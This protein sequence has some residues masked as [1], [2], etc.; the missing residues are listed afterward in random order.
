[1]QRSHCRYGSLAAL[2]LATGCATEPTDT[3]ESAISQERPNGIAEVAS[4]LYSDADATLTGYAV[5]SVG[6]CT[7]QMIGPNMMMTAAH[8]DDVDR[9]ATFFVYRNQDPAQLVTETFFCRILLNT[10]AGSDLTLYA[11][12]PNAAGENP[13]DKYGYLDFDPTQPT[14]N[15]KVYSYWYNPVAS[16][17]LNQALIYSA[18]KVT[19]TSAG[20]W[21]LNNSGAPMSSPIGIG[22]DLWSQPGCSGSAIIDAANHRIMAGPTSTGANDAAGR[23]ALSAK[24]GFE[25]SSV[26]GFSEATAG[27]TVQRTGVDSDN[28][29]R[30]NRFIGSSITPSRYAGRLDKDNDYVF[31]IQERIERILG[32]NQRDWYFLGFN[33]ERR[34]A[35][36]DKPWYT[37]FNPTS[38][39]AHINTPS[40]SL[41]GWETLVHRHLPLE[42]NTKYRVSLMINVAD[43]SVPNNLRVAL[44]RANRVIGPSIVP[45]T[46]VPIEESSF[47][48]PTNAGSGWQLV[49]FALQTQSAS[50]ELAFIV[51]GKLDALLSSV[52]II[53]DDAVMDFDSA[54]K[55]YSWR[56]DNTGGR[57]RIVPDGDDALLPDWA[58]WVTPTAGLA[59]GTDWPLRNRQLAIVPGTP[60]QLCVDV[61][62]AATPAHG[63]TTARSMRLLSAGVEVARTNFIPTQ[64]WTQTCTQPFQVASSDNNLQL[65]FAGPSAS[66]GYYADNIRLVPSCVPNP[67]V[68][69]G[70]TCG[71]VDD[72]CGNQV[73]C[74]GCSDGGYCISNQ[75]IQTCLPNRLACQNLA[76]G[77]VDDGCGHQI[78]CGTC[79]SRELCI[80]NQCVPDRWR[81][82]PVFERYRPLPRTIVGPITAPTH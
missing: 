65:G 41:T 11:C 25:R 44:R 51:G 34:N 32:E 78:D 45:T 5:A 80:V 2:L 71:T 67:K 10:F 81:V 20:I 56:N 64:N 16:L 46:H 69:S 58:A 9:N 6:G 72:G 37:T 36:W 40:V 77:K 48:V 53:R 76:C 68:C 59:A 52:S 22:T 79:A 27:G 82:P 18:G 50:P 1:M 29:L 13:G 63:D 14:V 38:H 26:D 24:T 66:V 62:Q 55:R 43:S 54:D 49:T 12:D 35:L 4:R 21:G 75:C 70:M 30:F 47:I 61:R 3:M 15:Q 17:G 7:G 28:I 33:S 19:T 23:W 8:C 73:E 42:A 39:T 31:D 60:Y 57:G 74:G